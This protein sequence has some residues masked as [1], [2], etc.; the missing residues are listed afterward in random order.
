[1][2]MSSVKDQAAVSRSSGSAGEKL[3]YVA[4]VMTGCSSRASG[5]PS[6]RRSEVGLVC[7]TY[8]IFE[9]RLRQECSVIIWYIVYV[10]SGLLLM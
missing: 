7:T 8:Y 2:L 6:E 3:E 4:Q 5:V 10:S 9:K 1:M